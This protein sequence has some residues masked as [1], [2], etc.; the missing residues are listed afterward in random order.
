MDPRAPECLDRVDVS[1]ARDRA[2]IEE[3]HLYRRTRAPAQER[4]EPCHGE[5]TRERLLPE[6]GV[7]RPTASGA[8]GQSPPTVERRRIDDRH[9]S[10]LARVGEA[11]RR[12]VL[13]TNLPADVAL[14]D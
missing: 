4:A 6:R 7:Q 3:E 5:A 8:G 1:D 11:H 12:P 10:E 9:A 14:I 2:L 13:E